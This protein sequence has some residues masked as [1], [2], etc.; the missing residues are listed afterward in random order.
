[1]GEIEVALMAA[2][3]LLFEVAG[4]WSGRDEDRPGMMARLAAAKMA[5]STAANDATEKALQAAG[6]ASLTRALPLERYFRDVR[7]AGMQPPAG[8]TAYEAVGR[9]ALGL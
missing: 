9:A 5:V 8:D 3:A 6:G 1:M 7:A 4:S 2:R